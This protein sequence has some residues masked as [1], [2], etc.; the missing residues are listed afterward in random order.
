MNCHVTASALPERSTLSSD[1]CCVDWALRCVTLAREESCGESVMCR[2]GLTQLFLLITD[3]TSG[4]AASQDLDTIRDLCEVMASTE[5]CILAKTAAENV[6][7]TLTQYPEDW[8][9]HARR[10]R[11][12]KLACPAY[13][14]LY[15]DPARCKGAHACLANLPEGAIASGDGMI[16]VIL[17]ES[18]LKTEEFIARCPNGAIQKAGAVKPALPQ[19][20]IPVGSF[21]SGGSVRRRRRGT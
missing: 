18:T 7:Y 16:S 2:E 20:P 19:A 9:M 5:G 11:C 13:Y 1:T 6:L 15:I 21:E 17:D 4:R 8:D 3:V 12:A 10:K 14:T